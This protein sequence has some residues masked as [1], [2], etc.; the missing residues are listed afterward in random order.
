M[1]EDGTPD[2]NA[3]SSDITEYSDYYDL[4]GVPEDESEEEI[5]KRSRKL[6]AK[7][8]PD[9]SNHPDADSIF[10]T[11]N[12]AQDVLTDK[13]Q[14]AIY[15]SLGHDQYVQRREEDGEM[16]LSEDITSGTVSTG[17]SSTSDGS[18]DSDSE[19]NLSE[20]YGSTGRNERNT[21]AGRIKEHG[22]YQSI[23]ELDM[24]ATAEESITR[25]YR[26]FWLTR[27]LCILAFA[28]VSMY[29]ALNDPARITTT[30]RNIGGPSNYAFAS[31]VLV[32]ATVFAAAITFVGGSVAYQLLKPAARE[33]A[34]QREEE[35]NEASESSNDY[36]RGLNTKGSPSRNSNSR[37]AWDAPTRYDGSREEDMHKESAETRK[38][39]SLKYG[40]RFLLLGI[41][42]TTIGA[43]MS[44]PHPWVYLQLLLQGGGVE[45][46]LWW[47][48]GG[49]N[50]REID[51]LLNATYTFLMAMFTVIGGIFTIRGLSRE[52]WHERYY[53]GRSVFP[54]LWDTFIT[55]S[56]VI[57]IAGLLFG[58]TPIDA[59]TLSNIPSPALAYV[60]GTD[61][62][63]TL[64]IAI[65]GYSM[66][67]G[68][69]ILF[70]LRTLF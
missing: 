19:L 25:M 66:I 40:S 35:Q 36:N 28:G 60:A 33:L 9:I 59:I 7:Y 3:D 65:V 44:G 39:S 49:E 23:T 64:S 56:G 42:M 11:I 14:R 46:Q 48:V 45:T 22:S 55:V 41:V 37:G 1:T 38:N 12:R 26:K 34:E 16:T 62:I 32:T 13:E 18:H 58:T 61:G 69:V 20:D 67:Y 70:K 24:N 53:E 68:S 31:V 51:V 2:D 43:A 5:L 52:V 17:S 4:L 54:V 47:K 8:H 6:L 30:W 10:K 50:A 29:F 21:W 57:G 27:F 63:T 15:E